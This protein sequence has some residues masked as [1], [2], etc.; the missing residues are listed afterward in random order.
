MSVESKYPD[1]SQYGMKVVTKKQFFGY[2]GPRDIT[3]TAKRDMK[4]EYGIYVDFR[5]REGKLVGKVFGD[6]LTTVFML[7]KDLV[8]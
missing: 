1:P 3:T 6:Y 4:M 2:I 7:N 5:F 8:H